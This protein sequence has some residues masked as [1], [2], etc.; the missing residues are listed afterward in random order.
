LARERRERREV[1]RLEEQ[2]S[3]GAER[4]RDWLTWRLAGI[5]LVVTQLVGTLLVGSM[6]IGTC[7]TL[8]R[9]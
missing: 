2:R 4:R 8:L 5:R 1:R 3:R 6:L 7:G 9:T